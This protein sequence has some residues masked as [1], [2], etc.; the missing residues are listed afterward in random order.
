MSLRGVAHQFQVWVEV[1][2][3]C[4][5]PSY[6]SI[7]QWVLRV[8]LYEWQRPKA[9]QADWIFVIDLTIELGSNK[10]LV[11]LGIRQTKWAAIVK[12][13]GRDLQH[14]DMDVLQISVMGSTQGVYIQQQIEQV[15]LQVGC[16]LQIVSDHGSD[17]KK[18]IELYLQEHPKVIYTYD[19]TH[20]TARL[21]KAELE[22]DEAYQ[23]F[24]QR[25]TRTR[26]Q[27]QQS[28]LSFLMPPVQR[29]KS[30][31]LNIESLFSWAEQI[32][33]YAQRQDFAAI[34]PEFC[35]DE[36]AFEALS[37]KLTHVEWSPLVVLKHQV[38]PHRR[39]FLQALELHLP[40]QTYLTWQPL[41]L[42]VADCGRRKF[43]QALGW[44]IESV[45]TLAPF[46]KML[47]L[48]ATLQQQLKTQGL[49]HSTQHWFE[50]ETQ[51][52]DLCPRLQAF[53]AKLIDY[54]A[55]QT[56]ALPAESV[57]MGAS[58]IIES[59][60]GKY[61]LFSARTPLKHMGH[62]LLLLPLLTTSLSAQQIKLALE[63]CSFDQVETWFQET[64]GRSALAKRRAA[65]SPSKYT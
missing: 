47:S 5:T 49:T 48:V 29:A 23:R 20:Q 34:A 2:V 11:I 52:L 22:G 27:L 7:R 30:R 14:Q 62:L 33:H 59:I 9:R 65:F 36:P 61:K 1:G 56:Q 60:F 10:C 53:R 51:A 24:A 40:P 45:D 3:A 15:S 18:G 17:V 54:L 63:Q 41:L 21:L 42:Q 4:P 26:Q 35:L 12:E 28:P 55:Q 43:E 31:Y 38:Y 8:G 13:D 50:L 39:D 37:L 46:Q 16:P 25:C 32:Y 6:S 57:F 58:D 64:F 19:V 44:V